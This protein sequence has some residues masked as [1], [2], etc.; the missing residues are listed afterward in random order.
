MNYDSENV[1][2]FVG[3]LYYRISKYVYFIE[4]RYVILIPCVLVAINMML[5]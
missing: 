5:F 1:P 2:E 4:G 3:K